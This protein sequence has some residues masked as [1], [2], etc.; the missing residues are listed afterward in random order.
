VRTVTAVA[1]VTV[2]TQAPIALLLPL[3]RKQTGIGG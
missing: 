3:L 2:R 1:E